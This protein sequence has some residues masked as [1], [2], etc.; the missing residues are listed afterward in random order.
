MP[1]LGLTSSALPVLAGMLVVGLPVLAVVVW[2]R[3]PGPRAVRAAERLGL[4]VL[5]QAT[6]VLLAFVAVNDQY[7]FYTSWAELMGSSVAPGPIVTT[8]A[9]TLA[10]PSGRVQVLPA[11]ASRSADGGRLLS[12]TVRGARSGITAQVLVHLPPGYDSSRRSYPVVELLSGWHTGPSSW[13]SNFGL[14]GA[15]RAAERSGALG[16]VIAV[17]PELNVALPRDVECTDVPHGPQ[18]E[19]WLTTDVRDL[20]LAQFRALPSAASW[21][22]MGYS[23]GGY[24]AAKLAFHHPRWYRTSVVMAGY[25]DAVRDGTTGDL[26]GGS[27]MLR[28]L[29]SPSWL[30]AHRPPPA[31]DLLVFASRRDSESWASTARFLSL[32]R[33]PLQVDR[34]I[35]RA[36]GHNFEVVRKVLPPLLAWLGQHLSWVGPSRVPKSSATVRGA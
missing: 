11:T 27:A 35:A 18:A 14:L 9:V 36:G 20:V 29:N 25:F 22:L 30:V 24:C 32:A 12:E 17:M 7:Q 15:L 28:D 23:T 1:V 3:L 13:V 5:A 19:T 2:N 16:P 33:S 31:V 6:A 21:A 34:L 26:W 10:G 4:V 8:G